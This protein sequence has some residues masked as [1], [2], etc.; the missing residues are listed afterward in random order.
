MDAEAAG[1]T[2]VRQGKEKKELM[3][4]VS[5]NMRQ[6]LVDWL[7]DVHQSFELKEQTLYLTLTVSPRHPFH[8]LDDDIERTV[9]Y[10]TVAERVKS[11]AA[12]RPRRLIETLADEVARMVL[13]EFAAQEVAVEVEKHILPDTDAVTV[14][15][16][17][18]REVTE[19]GNGD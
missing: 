15:T 8:S 1:R 14:R 5:D 6:I 3:T 2:M 19:E 17:L 7:V 16:T 4:N 18:R 13:D 9:D 11:L 12:D 10:Y